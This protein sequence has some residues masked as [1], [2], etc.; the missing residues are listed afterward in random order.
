MMK[1]LACFLLICF[2]LLLF[3]LAFHHHAD[4]A[5]HDNCSICSYVSN[6]SVLIP[7]DSPQI[8]ILPLNV[9]FI[10]IENTVCFSY[11]HYHSYSNRAP[12]A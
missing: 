9:L 10:T 1:K 6:H 4:G 7:Q 12:P 2:S 11:L 5:S 3:G 8:S